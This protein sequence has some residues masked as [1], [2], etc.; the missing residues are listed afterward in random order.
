ML[1]L[2]TLGENAVEEPLLSARREELMRACCE[3]VRK[4]HFPNRLDGSLCLLR[5]ASQIHRRTPYSCCA[6]EPCTVS[7]PEYLILLGSDTCCNDTIFSAGDFVSAIYFVK[8]GE[9]MVWDENS[10]SCPNF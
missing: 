3:G 2:R 7:L 8:R 4:P 6:V 9:V 1:S 10:N 5:T